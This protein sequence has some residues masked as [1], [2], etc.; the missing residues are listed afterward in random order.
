MRVRL[1]LM[2]SI[3][4]AAAHAQPKIQSGGV[5]NAASYFS[6]GG[7]GFNPIAPGSYF[8]IF[9]SGL[10]PSTLAVGSLPFG[11]ALPG[12]T[13]TSVTFS[14]LNGPSY[15]AYLYYAGATQ[16][17]GIL[18]SNVPPQQYNVTV[19]YNGV[20]SK[21]EP[22]F[23]TPANPGLFTRNQAGFGTVK[24]QAFR[25]ATDYFEPTLSAPAAPGQVI[26]LYGTGLGA[27]NAPDNAAPGA[28]QVKGPVTVYVNGEAVTPAYAGRSPQ[29]P[30]LDQI[31]FTLP[32]DLAPGCYTDLVVGVAGFSSNV[33]SI[34]TAAA[35]ATCTHPL[36]L[37]AAA[38]AK[39]DAGGTVNVGLLALFSGIQAGGSGSPQDA[40][41]AAIFTMNADNVVQMLRQGGNPNQ[42]PIRLPAGSCGLWDAN[43]PNRSP[44]LDF[45]TWGTDLS[46]ASAITLTN[47][48]GKAV[49]LT[50][51]AA[52]GLGGGFI[53]L[54]PQGTLVPGAWTLAA[55][56]ATIGTVGATVT[57]PPVVSWT[58]PPQDG[59]SVPR[60][61]TTFSWTGGGGLVNVV[62]QAQTSSNG[63]KEF[64]CAFPATDGKG[65]V[66]ASV[67]GQLPL[68]APG[69][70]NFAGV[71]AMLADTYGTFGTPGKL[72]GSM[73]IFASGGAH[74]V[75]WK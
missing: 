50:S 65:T 27:A 6:I 8:V 12:A 71:L 66:P 46:A 51:G 24:A 38:L 28:V 31:N 70:S 17:S 47:P 43:G 11:T 13:G 2:L 45:T 34:P 1:F 37:N 33:V 75:V 41:V 54:L 55:S 72:D 73:T 16:V 44:D 7:Q 20:T 35:G 52:A 74:A 21:P 48:T 32:T 22:V 63:S 36:G 40:A 9:G 58:G 59:A 61:A 10:G 25:S 3:A 42:S 18:P 68:P 56:S 23:V 67:L 4:A 19:T 69:D 26:A 60:T 53:A 57:A 30:G 29:Y 15:K 5:V 64:T 62:G 49:S 39:L 14:S